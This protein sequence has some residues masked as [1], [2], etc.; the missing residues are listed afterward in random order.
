MEKTSKSRNNVV[1]V[2]ELLRQGIAPHEIR[3]FF[4][5]GLMDSHRHTVLSRKTL[6][7]LRKAFL[8]TDGVLGF[9]SKQD[10]IW[11]EF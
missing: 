5:M 8:D 1:Y 7:Q 3:F 11:R 6:Q 9:F 4:C 2:E 10:T